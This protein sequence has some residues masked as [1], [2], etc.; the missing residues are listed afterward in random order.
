MLDSRI[1]FSS[2]LLLGFSFQDGPALTPVEAF[3]QKIKD[4]KSP[5]EKALA[6]QALGAATPRNS[7]MVALIAKYLAPSS[8]D[9]NYLMATVATEAL[10]RFRGNGA[11][12]QALIGA[13]GIYKK[14]PYMAGRIQTAIGKVGHES[15]LA[16]FEEGLKGSDPAAAVASV[17]A[18]AN[19]PALIALD[20]LFREND[21]IEKRKAGASDEL[22]QF[23]ERVQPEILKALKK[24]S[25]QPWTS[26]AEYTI[27][28][29]KRGAAFREA[30]EKKERERQDA[31]VQVSTTL[32]PPL[33]VELLFR[34]NGGQTTVN[35]GTSGGIHPAAALSTPAPAWTATAPPNGGPSAIEWPVMTGAHAVDLGGGSGVDHLKNL[36]SFT[37]TG[38]ISCAEAKEGPARKNV[39]GGNCLV[40]WLKNDEGVELVCRSDGSLQLGINQWADGSV[41]KSATDQVKVYDVTAK[42]TKDEQAA[43]WRFFAVTYDSTIVAGHA[44][45]YVGTQKS[46]LKIVSTVDYDRGS[47]GAKIAS[48]L[49]VGN[50]VPA[51]RPTAP[52]RA[53]R[54]IIDEIRIF[55]SPF[56]GGGALPA[57][58]LVK[59]QNRTS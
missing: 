58:D 34:E 14:I 17:Q 11:A 32:P 38:W 7:S 41:A 55:G 19:M 53:F 49:A 22:K 47:V 45:F 9:I 39:G 26:M 50:V 43:T 40:T 54:G 48:H 29:T 4:A 51:L 8:A 24:L 10:A 35:S 57:A 31:V 25:G 18:I 33:L 56:D 44:K 12:S 23:H 42:N 3:K 13:M 27:W 2:L 15:G 28:W 36:K 6:I 46:D 21:R 37:I 5:H 20:F 30:E 16:L 59:V 52:E 1:V